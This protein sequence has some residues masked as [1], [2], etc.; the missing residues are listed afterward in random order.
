MQTPGGRAGAEK[1][2]ECHQNTG[3]VE[4]QPWPVKNFWIK[5][6]K[7]RIFTKEALDGPTVSR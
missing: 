3:A 2:I 4:S 6:P 1:Y 7:A 5:K